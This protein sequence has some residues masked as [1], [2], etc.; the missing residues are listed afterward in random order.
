MLIVRHICNV[1]YNNLI[2][3]VCLLLLMFNESIRI[4]CWFLIIQ[5]NGKFFTSAN[6]P[7]A[8]NNH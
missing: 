3:M 2:V 6:A 7:S 5:I 1:I 4:N 8:T